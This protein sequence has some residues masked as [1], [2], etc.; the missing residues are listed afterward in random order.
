MVDPEGVVWDNLSPKHLWPLLKYH[1][2]IKMRPCL[3]LIEV[4]TEL[5]TY[6]AGLLF[7]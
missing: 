2:L 7:E 6:R 3:V 5:N 1:H 4:K